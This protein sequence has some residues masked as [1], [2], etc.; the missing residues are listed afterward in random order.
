MLVRLSIV[1][2]A[3]LAIASASFGAVQTFIN[4]YAGFQAAAGPLSII[5]FETLPDGSPST[6]G[7]PITAAFNYDALGAHFSA[8]LSD[9][10]IAGNAMSQFGFDLVALTAFPQ[11]TWIDIDLVMPGRAIGVFFPGGTRLFVYDASGALIASTFYSSPGGGHFLGLVSDSPIFSAKVDRGGD[12]EDIHSVVFDNI[13][14]PA[15]ALFLSIG[16]VFVRARV[17]RTDYATRS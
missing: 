2:A 15:S 10:F 13:P 11:R 9:P 12:A 4:D 17:A 16:A 5:D 1:L 7:T 3:V 8:P 14:E 6:A